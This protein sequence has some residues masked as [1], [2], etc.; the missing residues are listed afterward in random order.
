MAR[1]G[2]MARRGGMT[3][4]DGTDGMTEPTMMTVTMMTRI[5]IGM[6]RVE[7][8]TPCTSTET[9]HPTVGRRERSHTEIPTS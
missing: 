8:T 1:R 5:P 6:T 4:R 9:A 3:R 2:R 7:T